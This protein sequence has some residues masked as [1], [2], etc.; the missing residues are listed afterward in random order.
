MKKKA[1]YFLM[2]LL[3]AFVLFPMAARAEGEIE[4]NEDTF[5]DEI[6]RGYVLNSIDADGDGILTQEECSAVDRINVKDNFIS[7]LKGI[8]YFTNLRS[9]DCSSNELAS[10]DVTHNLALSSLTCGYNKLTSLDIS[11]NPA[12][13][14]LHLQGNPI[15]IINIGNNPKLKTAVE[16]GEKSYGTYNHF[17][18]GYVCYAHYPK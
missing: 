6:F 15:E 16:N 3:L 4:I 7:S 11:N 1:I 10:L 5:P 12:L 2:T 8:E 14:F 9:L 18:D 13:S 17:E